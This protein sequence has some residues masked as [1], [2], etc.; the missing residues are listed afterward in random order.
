MGRWPPC[1]GPSLHCH[2]CLLPV[3]LN[4]DSRTCLLPRRNAA[5]RAA[6]LGGRGGRAPFATDPPR[7]RLPSPPSHQGAQVLLSAM[8]MPRCFLSSSP[9]SHAQAP[10]HCLRPGHEPTRGLG[11][12]GRVGGAFLQGSS[13]VSHTRCSPPLRSPSLP[14]PPC[15]LHPLQGAL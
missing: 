12:P 5:T 11:P 8:V 15:P 2:L 9:L 10:S 4:A 13:K 7:S 1:P 14:C 6:Q 3:R